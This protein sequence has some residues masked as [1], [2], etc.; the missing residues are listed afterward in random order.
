MAVVYIPN[1]AVE[2]PSQSQTG[3][4]GGTVGFTRAFKDEYDTLATA[5]DGIET[6][7]DTL[8]GLLVKSYTLQRTPGD[9][10]VL[11]LSLA[12]DDTSGDDTPSQTALKAVWSCK[13]T[14]NDVSILGY[15]GG[16]ASR[17]N[18]ELWQK[19]T[20][21]DLADADTFHKNDT[22]TDQLNSQEIAI[23]DKIRKGIE[24]V[25]R[26][27]PVLSC[28]SYWSRIPQKFMTNLGFID[29][30]AAPSA[31]TVHAPANL[32]TIISAH[33]WLKVQ[34]DVS[35]TGDGKFQRVES[36]MGIPS[37]DSGTGWDP[38]LYGPN[39]W[40]MP[41]SSASSSSS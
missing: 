21:A 36:W 11:T 27:Y 35:E 26:F 2:Q 28:T 12:P 32:S 18:L 38:E 1:T 39:R 29:S 15:C 14:R 22:D 20:D 13:S 10:G 24:S 4:D 33:S 17:V 7:V 34:D 16:A 23:A 3:N 6:G 37:S 41:I 40:P 30:P 5:A 19:E 8:G 9:M 31:N 25:I